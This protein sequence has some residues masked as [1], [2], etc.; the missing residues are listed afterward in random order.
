MLE[1]YITFIEGLG[2]I[3]DLLSVTEPSSGVADR[4]YLLPLKSRNYGWA[5]WFNFL[6]HCIKYQSKS[7]QE[8]LPCPC[9]RMGLILHVDQTDPCGFALTAGGFQALLQWWEIIRANE[10]N[11]ISLLLSPLFLRTVSR[12]QS[13]ECG[14]S[15]EHWDVPCSEEIFHL[16]VGKEMVVEH[17]RGLVNR[18]HQQLPWRASAWGA[19]WLGK[20]LTAN[21][22]LFMRKS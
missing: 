19:K 6:L 7:G 2:Y 16:Y 18:R 17:W 12:T 21:S 10:P 9:S 3:L 20:E 14:E 5:F 13:V 1:V 15:R 8:Y 4:K 11:I 22:L